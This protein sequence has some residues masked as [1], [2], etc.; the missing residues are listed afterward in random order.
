WVKTGLL[1]VGWGMA[2]WYTALF[3]HIFSNSYLGFVLLVQLVFLQSGPRY[4]IAILGLVVAGDLYQLFTHP[5]TNIAADAFSVVVQA[6]VGVVSWIFV[7]AAN[8]MRDDARQSAQEAI[9]ATE[10]AE[11]LTREATDSRDEARRLTAEITQL[12]RLIITSQD[13]ER[14][15]MARDVHDGPLQAMGV[16]LLAMDRAR[17][18]LD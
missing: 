15:R 4:G 7:S 13:N 5:Y 16:E 17:R 1:F 12:N 8:T 18:Y 2:S 11:Y 14:R 9:A 3:S 6:L 10:R